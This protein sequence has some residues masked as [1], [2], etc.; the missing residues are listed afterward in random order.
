[1]SL[2]LISCAGQEVHEYRLPAY[3]NR[4]LTMDVYDDIFFME[5][6]TWE[7]DDRYGESMDQ[8]GD[9]LILS[10][11]DQQR[12]ALVDKNES[13]LEQSKKQLKALDPAYDLK[14]DQDAGELTLTIDAAY[15]DDWAH[16]ADLFTTVV[17]AWINQML[18]CDDPDVPIDVKVINASS[19]HVLSHALFPYQEL[20][21]SNQ[22]LQTSETK[23]VEK[24]SNIPGG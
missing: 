7:I 3:A 18:I 13:L 6:E 21:I 23:D 4:I 24:G 22:D 8:E 14:W 11:S 12:D 20:S 2:F 19:G 16:G 17:I 1:M 5:D 10:A 15:I 9:V